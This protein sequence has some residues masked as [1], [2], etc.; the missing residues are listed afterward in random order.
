M[1]IKMPMIASMEILLLSINLHARNHLT[2]LD[3]P[4][5]IAREIEM[6]NKWFGTHDGLAAAGRIPSITRIGERIT[7]SEMML[8]I[9]CGVAA[10]A[11][12]GLLHRGL[13]LPGSSIVFSLI[14]MALGLALAPRRNAGFIMGSGALGAAAIFNLAGLAHYGAGAFISLCLVGPIMD[15]A[16]ARARTGWRLYS[17][18]VV[19]GIITNMLALGSRGMSKLAGLDLLDMRPFGSWWAQAIITYVLAGAIA[20]LVGAVCFFH[21]SKRRTES[22]E[23]DDSGTNQ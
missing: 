7:T 22:P 19:A 5:G 23:S 15:F 17:G 1:S 13:R 21:L 8:L 11:S 4:A 3:Q 6:S 18:L 16:V 20:G 12:S 2:A 10:A 9:M 14:P